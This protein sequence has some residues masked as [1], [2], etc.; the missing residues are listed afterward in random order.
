MAGTAFAAGS[1]VLA[2]AWWTFRGPCGEV[3]NSVKALKATPLRQVAVG[4][5]AE[6]SEEEARFSGA[7]FYGLRRARRQQ[8]RRVRRTKWP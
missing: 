6:D 4:G 3:F 5:E 2:V 1:A 7:A 8:K